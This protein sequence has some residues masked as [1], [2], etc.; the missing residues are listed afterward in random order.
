MPG[1]YVKP[2]TIPWVRYNVKIKHSTNKLL[3]RNKIGSLH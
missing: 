3:R 1:I 2:G